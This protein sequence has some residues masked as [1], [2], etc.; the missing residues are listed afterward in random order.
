MLDGGFRSPLG[1]AILRG[2]KG[3]HCKV[4]QLSARALCK[5]GEPIEMPFGIWTRAGPRKHALGEVHTGATW[6]IPLN[7]LCAAAM[8]PVV[9]LL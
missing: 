7:R 6:R 9:K 3:A 8:R 5:N 1:R 4:S 2:K